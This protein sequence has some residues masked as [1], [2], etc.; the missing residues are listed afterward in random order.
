MMH[1]TYLID[2]ST[3]QFLEVSAYLL[4]AL[5]VWA[6]IHVILY[7]RDARSAAAW[8]V[9]ILLSPGVGAILYLL[10]GINRIRRKASMLKKDNSYLQWARPEIG[11]RVVHNKKLS[12]NF[13]KSAPAHI[14]DLA[15]CGDSILNYPV[16]RGNSVKVLE[17]DLAFVAML[18]AIK[19]ARKT[20]TLQ[21]Y[22]FDDD[23]LGKL[24]IAALGDAVARGV[25]V[26]VLIDGIG[27]KYSLPPV[28]KRLKKEKIPHNLFLRPNL[29]FTIA[30]FNLRCHRKILVVDG[31]TGFTGG[32][33]IRDGYKSGK[34]RL[35]D[36]HFRFEGPV[37]HYFQKIFIE[38]WEFTTREKLK[39][40]DW[41]PVL[42]SG[43]TVAAR[44]F[45][46]GPDRNFENNYWM[47]HSAISNARESIYIQTPY[48][49]PDPTLIN[50][51]C[52]ASL[53]G[54][55]V[56]ILIPHDGNLA[57][58]QWAMEGTVWRVIEKGCR[59]YMLKKPFDHSKMMIIDGMWAL[60][61]TSNWDSR[62]M[63]LNFEFD[64]ECYDAVTAKK[65]S[66]IF[67]IKL[68]ESH[69]LTL[70]HVRG[71]NFLKRLRNGAA[72]LFTPYL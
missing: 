18:K 27:E 7:K 32:M 23:D 58:V 17:N 38:D 65:L 2:K 61:G 68:K 29:P 63:R 41:L 30:F 12:K 55:D 40:A 49:V 26:R 31:R 20:I 25:Q 60:V 43:G 4:L 6:V 14:K 57:V 52:L 71:T 36:T 33:N 11:D 47:L 44:A 8:I 15:H 13:I 34:R 46:S 48:F 50:A 19:S 16:E 9:I 5:S 3:M 59:V 22:I 10:L 53:Q 45:A 54:V 51:L 70:S 21:T 35:C 1:I 64:V 69:E 28:T 56:K 66:N 39:G 62:S 72:R 24:F 42:K 67:M 37:V